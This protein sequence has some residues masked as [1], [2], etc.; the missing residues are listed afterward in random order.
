MRAYIALNMMP[1]PPRLFE[2]FVVSILDRNYLGWLRPL[3]DPP[4]VLFCVGERDAV[5]RRPVA[6]VGR[7]L[8]QASQ[9]LLEVHLSGFVRKG[10]DEYIRVL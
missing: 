2:W 6:L 1:K 9:G 4:L 7:D 5:D 3:P 10:A 8:Q